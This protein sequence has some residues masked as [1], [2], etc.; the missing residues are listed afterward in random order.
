MSSRQKV[1]PIAKARA[2][3]Q[4]APAPEP[5]VVADTTP[6]KTPRK[7]KDSPI[8]REREGVKSGER[9][10]SPA[11]GSSSKV[12]PIARARES[13]KASPQLIHKSLEVSGE[14]DDYEFPPLSVPFG[15]ECYLT[16]TEIESAT[17][18]IKANKELKFQLYTVDYEEDSK[19][20]KKEYESVL[21]FGWF[22]PAVGVDINDIWTSWNEKSTKWHELLWAA[23]LMPQGKVLDEIRYPEMLDPV[24]EEPEESEDQ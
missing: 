19:D 21:V 17:A 23:K 15:L 24:E 8:A 18:F 9:R 1:S 20:K 10:A 5:A 22:R 2:S 12:S 11:K 6:A 4:A 13:K 16:K 7:G 14:E 3:K